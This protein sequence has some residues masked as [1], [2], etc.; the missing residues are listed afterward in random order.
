MPNIDKAEQRSLLDGFNGNPD[1]I[2]EKMRFDKTFRI[3]VSGDVLITELE[4]KIIDTRDFQRLRGVRQLGTVNLVFPTALHT[5]FDHSIGTLAMSEKMITAITT[6]TASSDS[7]KNITPLQRAITRLYALLHDIAHVPFGHTLE[8]ELRLFERHDENPGRLYRFLGPTSDIAK[9]IISYLGQDAYD[10]FMRIYLWDDDKEIRE[11][12]ISDPKWRALNK[13]LNI[14]HDD[15][16]IHD[17]VSNTV[18]ADLLDY[19]MRDN[20]FCNLG[21][22]LEYRFLNFLYLHVPS[23]S[24]D[25]RRRVFV[26]L[27]KGENKKPR[28]DTLTDLVR[29]LEARYMIAERAYFHHTKLI[30]GAMLGRALQEAKGAG[31]IT[32]EQLYD[33]SDDSILLLLRHSNANVA[34]M[35]GNRICDRQLLKTI[36][37][38]GDEAFRQAQ[39]K[40]HDIEFKHKALSLL[41][42][43]EDRRR[44][45]DEIAERIGAKPGALLIYAPPEKMNL[46]LAKMRVRW[47]GADKHLFE[48]DDPVIGPR[49]KE[50]LNAH[51]L[52]WSIWLVGE[53]S[54]TLDQKALA[55][56]EFK[57]RFL[58]RESDQEQRRI[59]HTEALLDIQLGNLGAVFNGNMADFVIKRREVAQEFMATSTDKRSFIVR[60]KSAAE[61]ILKDLGS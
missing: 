16:F 51:Q 13:W 1:D 7:E 3:A 22:S 47:K 60:L 50:T 14:A 61:R 44:I 21:I 48:I 54:L 49:L 40:D 8:D 52:L 38:F 11:S 19:L 35:L 24:E 4:R 20:Y 43:P 23:H 6:N 45:E 28:R 26:R 32:E 12:R 46:K 31:E 27:W 25:D 53:S 34:E 18:C 57:L 29:L 55:I 2:D 37:V 5:R 33:H 41:S 10:R 17:I 42:N 59:R 9:L 36:E 30:T 15:V 58:V 56:E 39:E